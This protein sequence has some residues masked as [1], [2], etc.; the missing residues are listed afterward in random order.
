[1]T[2]VCTAGRRKADTVCAGEGKERLP[3]GEKLDFEEAN[4][5]HLEVDGVVNSVL[6][7]GGLA[8]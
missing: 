3:G 2:A 4:S 6:E 8:G 1:M 5:G 7:D